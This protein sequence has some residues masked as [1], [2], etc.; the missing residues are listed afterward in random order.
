MKDQYSD[1]DVFNIMMDLFKSSSRKSDLTGYIRNNRMEQVRELLNRRRNE[2]LAEIARYKERERRG[3]E[4]PVTEP[5]TPDES[6]NEF[7][8]HEDDVAPFSLLSLNYRQGEVEGGTIRSRARTRKQIGTIAKALGYK[9][10]WV[11]DKP[12]NA[13]IDTDEKVLYLNIRTDQ[14]L[15]AVMGHEVTHDLRKSD[16][17]A[18]E[19]LK[20][21]AKDLLGHH[22][23]DALLQVGYLLFEPCKQPLGNL[24]QKDATLAAGVE[25]A[26]LRTAE[27][28]MRQQVEHTVGQLRRSENLVAREVGQTVENIRAI[29][30]LHSGIIECNA[31]ADKYGQARRSS[32]PRPARRR[33][34]TGVSG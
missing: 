14:P 2:E 24:P 21:Y 23:V 26:C 25:K 10:R 27:Q 5:V 19:A 18:Y 1:V 13:K 22:V 6:A 8:A 33:G 32:V 28:L 29:I 9:I 34:N 17:K 7:V 16:S 4:E 31:M 15:A 20:R 3:E 30:I 12:Y 11:A